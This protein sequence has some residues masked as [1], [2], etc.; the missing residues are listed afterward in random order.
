M[1][2]LMGGSTG[3]KP[4]STKV[5]APDGACEEAIA[6]FKDKFKSAPTIVVAAPGRVN[7]I[8][9]HTDYQEG[10]VFPIALDRKCVIALAP[11]SKGYRIYSREVKDTLQVDTLPEQPQDGDV[12][13]WS[14]VVGAMRIYCD[15]VKKPLP[16]GFD[17]VVLTTVPLGGG[18]SSSAAVEV[19]SAT[20]MEVAVGVSMAPMEKAVCCQKAE[21]E[22]AKMP[23]GLMDQAI[24]C[25][26]R[27]KHAML[28]DCRSKQPSLVPMEADDIDVLIIDSAV[29]H[30]LV[31]GA[32]STRKNQCQKA[33][34]IVQKKH[35]KVTMLR[36]VTLAMLEDAK[37]AGEIDDEVMST[38]RQTGDICDAACS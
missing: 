3:D 7:M 6:V 10:F 22:W 2:N 18:L 28:L 26:G 38:R 16:E 11:T 14:Y 32:Y 31:D 13:W 29:R 20:A 4:E 12:P 23:C 33:V 36:D 19:A 25:C 9:E 8:G 30:A 27:A 35:P 5:V 34:E 17:A 21:H 37:A 1:G 15:A 24:S